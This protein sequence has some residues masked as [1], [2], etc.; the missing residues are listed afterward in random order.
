MSVATDPIRLEE[1]QNRSVLQSDLPV[2]EKLDRARTELLDLSA[3]NRLLNIPRGARGAKSVTIVDELSDEVYAALVCK[4][5]PFTFLPGRSEAGEGEAPEG[6]ELPELAQ[7]EDDEIDQNT[8]TRLQTRLTPSGLQ[9][10][11]LELYFDARTLE[12]EQGVN[13]LFLALGALKWIDP[14]NSANIRHAPLILV[15]VSLERGN[16]AEK[17]KLRLRQEEVACNLSL[18]VMLDRV[19][20]IRLLLR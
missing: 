6:D 15:P 3:R 2:R 14:N 7:P 4:G 10:R 9:K 5:R 17:F 13:I 11:L 1:E 20:G 8:D 16:A 19:H 12:E 18:E